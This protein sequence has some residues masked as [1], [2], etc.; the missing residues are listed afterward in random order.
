MFY[1]FCFFGFVIYDFVNLLNFVSLI[2]EEI[3]LLIAPF[4]VNDLDYYDFSVL[5]TDRFDFEL[6]F[7][8]L[9]KKFRAR[10]VL[11]ARKVETTTNLILDL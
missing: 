3:S 10:G 8:Y 2:L 4:S 7:I 6:L 5:L 11:H 1:V 9:L